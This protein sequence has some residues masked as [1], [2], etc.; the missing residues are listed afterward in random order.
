MILPPGGRNQNLLRTIISPGRC[1]LLEL[2]AG[3]VRWES[4]V[5]RY[6]KKLKDKMDDE[7]QADWPGSV[8]AGGTGESLDSQLQSP[9]NF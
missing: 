1:S 4:N 7:N 5:S 6:E 9:G 3:I 8:G 2:Q